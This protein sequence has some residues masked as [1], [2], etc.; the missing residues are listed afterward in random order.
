MFRV[1]AK[2]SHPTSRGVEITEHV[3]FQCEG[4]GNDAWN[5]LVALATNLRGSIASSEIK[6]V[7]SSG[8]VSNTMPAVVTPPSPPP[9][10]RVPWY[11]D[12][13]GFDFLAYGPIEV[14]EV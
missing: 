13:S 11:G 7:E 1:R 6:S 10:P 14:T 9:A 12:A 5:R 4:S 2:I 3:E 8:E